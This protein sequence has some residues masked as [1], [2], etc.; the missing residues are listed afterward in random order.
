M[1]GVLRAGYT[2]FPI[3]PRNSPQAIAH[4]LNKTGAVH[5]FVSGDSQL[6][7]LACASIKLLQAIE[8]S[9]AV[10]RY[11][12]PVFDDLFPPRAA[13]SSFKWFPLRC[14]DMEMPALILH[15]SGK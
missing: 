3:S 1:A 9:S 5:L 13:E 15:S 8:E 7:E 10:T 2:V 6:Y 4:L 14:F 11:E 12:I